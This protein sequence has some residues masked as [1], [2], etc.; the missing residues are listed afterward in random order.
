[1]DEILEN[2]FHPARVCRF[3]SHL[4]LSIGHLL[5]NLSLIRPIGVST[6]ESSFQNMN[7]RCLRTS[8]SVSFA[9]QLH[10]LF[11]SDHVWNI[12][13]DMTLTFWWFD[14]ILWLWTPTPCHLA[15]S[16]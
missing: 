3:A 11:S 8:P 12:M 9:R 14:I 1:M 2:D 16:Q 15:W 13:Q 10:D 6:R 7:L 4:G 5:F